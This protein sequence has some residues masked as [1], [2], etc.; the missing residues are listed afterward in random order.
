MEKGSYA[1]SEPGCSMVFGK[2]YM[3]F[4]NLHNKPTQIVKTSLTLSIAPS[5]VPFG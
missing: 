2:K 4:S 1:L 3:V 5:I